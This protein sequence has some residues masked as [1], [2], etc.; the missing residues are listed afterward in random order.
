MSFWGARSLTVPKDKGRMGRR[1]REKRRANTRFFHF[2]DFARIRSA[3]KEWVDGSRLVHDRIPSLASIWRYLDLTGRTTK[4]GVDRV[5]R[6]SRER[7]AK[8]FGNFEF[9][10]YQ[11]S[12]SY[13]ICTYT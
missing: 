13:I 3:V 1:E 5:R 6:S 11:S 8:I 2:L 12:Y 7:Y 4:S 9:L 10:P